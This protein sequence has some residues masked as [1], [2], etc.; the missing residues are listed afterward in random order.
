MKELP[1]NEMYCPPITIRC[2]DCRSFGRFVLVGSH[3]INNIHN[4]IYTPAVK[5][6]ANK[7]GMKKFAG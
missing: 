7:E 6:S 3:V 2:M 4:F 5:P 1:D